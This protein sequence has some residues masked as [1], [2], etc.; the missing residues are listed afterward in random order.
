MRNKQR[1][2][3]QHNK[4]VQYDSIVPHPPRETIKFKEGGNLLSCTSNA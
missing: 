2:D 3:L 4:L 1:M